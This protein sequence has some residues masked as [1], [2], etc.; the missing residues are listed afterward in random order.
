MQISKGYEI[1]ADLFCVSDASFGFVYENDID[2]FE[3][4]SITEGMYY[5]ANSSIYLTRTTGEK[6]YFQ[7]AQITLNRVLVPRKPFKGILKTK[8][9]PLKLVAIVLVD[10]E[11]SFKPILWLL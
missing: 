3:M 5:I 8:K 10:S 7:M 9:T 1:S 11:T 4:V 6:V 2:D